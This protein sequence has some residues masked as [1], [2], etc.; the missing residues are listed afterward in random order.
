[1]YRQRTL[2]KVHLNKSAKSR[3]GPTKVCV[4]H[5]LLEGTRLQL[6]KIT[7]SI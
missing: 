5:V 6:S 4:E 2:A 1:M 3:R 7:K